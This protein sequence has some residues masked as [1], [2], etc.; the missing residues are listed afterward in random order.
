MVR[1]DE[2]RFGC[3]RIPLLAALL[4][5]GLILPAVAMAQTP[6]V[7]TPDTLLKLPRDLTP[8][9]M[10][11]AADVV[12]K[13]V[14]VGLVFASV[15]TWTIWFAKAIE[16]LSA[17]KHMAAAVEALNTARSW[18]EV[19]IGLKKQSNGA[20]TLISAADTELKMSA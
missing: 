19:S 13:A 3:D 11:M 12:V 2:S 8:W 15:L 4:A 1:M 17:R 9:G 20:A 10:F 5:V 14:M 16:L 7:A 6:D 18:A